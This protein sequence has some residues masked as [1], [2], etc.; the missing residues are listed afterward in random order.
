MLNRTA[1]R[2][3]VGVFSP[4][5]QR[6]PWLIAV[7]YLSACG[8]GGGGG[9]GNA[10]PVAS[11]FAAQGSEDT[12]LSGALSGSDPEGKPVSYAIATK[13]AHGTLS[14]EAATGAFV[15]TPDANFSGSDTATF[16][17]SDGSRQS[18]AATVSFTIQPVNDAPVVASPAVAFNSA[19]SLETVVPL[20]VTD[21]DGD[22][23]NFTTS[24]SDP[25]VADVRIDAAAGTLVFTPRRKG[26]FDVGFVVTDGQVTASGQ[27]HVIVTEVT[28]RRAWTVS[29]P[30]SKA[31]SVTNTGANP[32]TFGWTHGGNPVLRNRAEILAH[33]ANV[34]GAYAA[35]PFEVQL[36]RF[37]TDNTYHWY[38][39]TEAYWIHDPLL[40]VNSIGFGF[41]DDV[42]N[43][44]AIL[45]QAAGYPTRVWWLYGHVVPEI[46]VDGRWEVLD[47]DLATYYVDA[48]GNI[49]GVAQ[50]STDAT[51]IT[52][53]IAPH[54]SLTRKSY[55]YTPELAAMYASMAD[56]R[57]EEQNLEGPT[58]LAGELTLP[59]GARLTYPG[60]WAPAPVGF[61][62]STP[63]E[64]PL[65]AQMR[66]ELPGDFSGPVQMPFL[67]WAAEGEGR[68]T[69]D[70]IDYAL[71]SAALTTRLQSWS[72]GLPSQISVTAS[73]P[74]SLVYLINP[75]R[76]GM[77]SDTAVEFQALDAWALRVELI[78]L[79][80]AN[81]LPAVAVQSFQKPH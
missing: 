37:L 67:L 76:Y 3:G 70:G 32:V 52:A 7:F 21:V 31:V 69:I 10:Q 19:E 71:G 4:E 12:A 46:A 63:Y 50:L 77:L 16:R 14:L 5:A 66:L 27:V 39:T 35:K 26:E 60:K 36:W 61:D 22:P 41:C 48:N 75:L 44:Y 47:P 56:N 49:A 2:L 72:A 55:A 74:V 53:P 33:A 62:G 45:G 1:N 13:P 43:A 9:P 64:A 51:L 73:G 25:G 18:A 38:P 15:Y 8:G 20:Q 40:M 54:F 6:L 78:D 29:T 11:A 81:Q 65:F 68:I 28:K 42:A 80:A 23:L 34:T 58:Q 59:V 79:A 17:V 24:V 30:N 57:I